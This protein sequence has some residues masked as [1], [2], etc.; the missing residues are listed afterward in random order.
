MLS[1]FY[2][3]TG[4]SKLDMC[5]ANCTWADEIAV[6]LY[7]WDAGTDSGLSYFVSI[8]FIFI[9]CNLWRCHSS[10][11]KW[12]ATQK[13]RILIQYNKLQIEININIDKLHIY[14]LIT[15]PNITRDCHLYLIATLCVVTRDITYL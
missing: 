10:H 1:M 5:R 15:S 14:S 9:N 11:V 13:L 2:F 6:D 8:T 12:N 3:Q 7:P 4:V